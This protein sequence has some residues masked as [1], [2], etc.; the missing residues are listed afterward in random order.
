MVF[1]YIYAAIDSINSYILLNETYLHYG[2]K[3]EKKIK[4]FSNLND[5]S[6]KN[7]Y[8][9]SGGFSVRY[10]IST[11]KIVSDFIKLGINKEYNIIV[12]EI[13]DH[14]SLCIYD[15]VI[16]CL[17]ENIKDDIEE[18]IFFG[19]SGGGVVASHIANGFKNYNYNI[20]IINYD[21]TFDVVNNV[22]NFKNFY[23]YRIDVL[24]Y[25]LVKYT[26]YNH[27]NYNEIKHLLVD[28]KYINGVDQFVNIV[29]KVQNFDDEQ[30][31]FY[32]SF[33]FDQKK[34]TKLI[35]I[36]TKNDPIIFEDISLDYKKK[37]YNDNL[38]YRHIQ[39]DTYGHI[40]DM[41]FSID[42]MKHILSALSD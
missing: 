42:Y 19:L 7:I 28:E 18:L 17:R 14:S 23:I 40:T 30:L 22:K 20:R 39:K 5:K 10:E 11:R 21:S 12:F 38:I 29:K 34:G 41:V 37:N 2:K 24:M 33:N 8:M 16:T 3:R 26:Y 4:I 31:L 1:Q 27:Y 36:N 25:F 15:D 6:K 35:T 9:F 13:L 32:S